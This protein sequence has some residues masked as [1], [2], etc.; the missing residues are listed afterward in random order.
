LENGS[1]LSNYHSIVGGIM[2]Q[3]YDKD[4]SKKKREEKLCVG[5]EDRSG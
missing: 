3:I 4:V 1:A 5:D 2:E